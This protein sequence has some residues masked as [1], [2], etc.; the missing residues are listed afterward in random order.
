MPKFKCSHCRLSFDDDCAIVNQ[1]GEKF[2]CTGCANVYE[3]L[4]NGGFD[5]FYS[6]LGTNTL[7]PQN[8]QNSTTQSIQSLYDEY[9][10]DENGFK[11]IS[12]VIEGI[13]CSA[14]IWLNEKVFFSTKGVVEA[15]INS[16]NNKAVVIWDEEQ[17][18]LAEILN[19]ISAVGYRAYAYDAGQEELR[20]S[21]KRR[22]FYIKLLVGVFC[23]MNIMWIAIAQYAG[24]FT[25]IDKNVRDILNF[26]EFIL[27]TPVLFYT[28]S[29]FF[30]G[31]KIALKT[32]TPNMDLL[33]VTGATLAYSY[34]V[35]SMFSRVGEVY[36]DSVA[37]IITFVFIGKFLEILSKKRANDTLDGLN[38][39]S[40]SEVS[41]AKDGAVTSKN[42]KD[43]K[44]GETIVLKAGDKALIDGVVTSGEASFDLSSLSGESLPVFLGVNDEL[45]SGSICLDGVVY[46]RAN[47]SFENS[48][49]NKIIS[50]LENATIKKPRIEQLANE[51]SS[52]FSLV[53]LSI[54]L[55]T[56]G[57]YFY[58]AWFEKAIVIAISVIVIACP[59]ALALATPVATLSA[60]GTG[61]RRGVLFKEAKFIES[62]AKCDTVV[63][64]K[65]GTLTKANLTVSEFAKFK[66]IDDGLI[67]SIALASKHPV[68]VAV[69]TY[70]KEAK[71]VNI[72]NVK[73]IAAKGVMAEFEGRN[74]LGGSARFMRENSLTLQDDNA[75]YFVAYDGEL[76]AKF[77]LKDELKSGVKECVQSLKKLGISAYVLSGDNEKNVKKVVDELKLK[78]KA[79]A[80]PDEKAKFVAK[81]VEDGKRV[82][83]VGDGINDSLAMSKAQVG[84]CMGS[85]ADISLERS[86][87]ALLNDDI[88][89]FGDSMVLAKRTFR[90]IKQN[91]AF[92]LCYNALTVPLA[93][94]GYV[95]PL[96]AA[97]SMSLSSIV[98]IL[99]S[100]RIKSTFKA[101]NG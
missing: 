35:Y 21:A 11:K 13:H 33:V 46:Y 41:V 92:S 5:E 79:N 86:D 53:I 38:L 50:M 83:F 90:T 101:K 10:K 16:T 36:F 58:A 61:L 100:L 77:V 97:L 70:L 3:I 9:V 39:L 18:G 48:L 80:L 23:V 78:Y 12:L 82:V 55:L 32:R 94:M 8:T 71:S 69:A 57:Y 84:V 81:L 29:A 44:V 52:K 7:S 37:M 17:V 28:G 51:I 26:A 87:V 93:V 25:G 20:M 34:S 27:A 6:R 4:H 43:V 1:N 31:A 76:V 66:D 15:S 42:I 56:F 59:C 49:L 65:T 89:A 19:A 64:D 68:S 73:E 14:C 45:K 47:A 67:L 22:D 88:T 96:F 63:F 30:S 2:C 24:Y 98:V 54:A 60:L 99:N 74:L 75:G 62:L 91:L 72:T 95:I 85:G 40:L